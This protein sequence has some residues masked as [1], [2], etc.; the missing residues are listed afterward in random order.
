MTGVKYA[1]MQISILQHQARVQH[2]ISALPKLSIVLES[3]YMQVH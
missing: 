2:T 3:I 1:S